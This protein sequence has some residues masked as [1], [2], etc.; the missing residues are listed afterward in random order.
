[1]SC[2]LDFCSNGKIED[3]FHGF[4]LIANNSTLLF[5]TIIYAFEIAFFNGLSATIT[6]YAS[7]THKAVVD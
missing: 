1:V 5:L 7:A 4:T 3:Y 6:R 2:D